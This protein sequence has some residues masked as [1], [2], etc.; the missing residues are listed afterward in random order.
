M[1]KYEYVVRPSYPDHAVFCVDSEAQRAPVVFRG[2]VN[3]CYAIRD[4]LWRLQSVVDDAINS[5][6]LVK[7]EITPAL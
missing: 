7:V 4:R 2:T 3:E 1:S 6:L 5:E